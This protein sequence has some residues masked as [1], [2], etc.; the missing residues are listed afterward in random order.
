[1]TF[2]RLFFIFVSINL[3][4]QHVSKYWVVF[5]DKPICKSA[6]AILSKRCLDNRM[7]LGIDTLQYTD[8]PVNKNY[9]AGLEQTGAAI[10]QKSK[11]LNAVSVTA[12]QNQLAQIKTLKYVKEILPLSICISV[13][14]IEKSDS[15]K[16]K[17]KKKNVVV[18]SV[19]AIEPSEALLS[20]NYSYFDKAKLS[21][22]GVVVGVADAGYLNLDKQDYFKKAIEEGRV[23]GTRDFLAPRRTVG[24]FENLTGK[25]THGR[26]VTKCI[27]GKS[28]KE[29][30]GVAYNAS[31]Y[32]ARTENAKEER[33]IEED[34]WVAAIEWFDSL[35]VRLVNSSLGYGKGFDD[36]RESYTSAE[37]N[38]YTTVVA[39]AA[40]IAATQ[41][42]MF[43]VN[44]AGNSGNDKEWKGYI[45]SPGDAVPVL[46]IGATDM[47]AAKMGYSSIG[48]E[49]NGYIKPDVSAFSKNGT[50][51][52]SPLIAGVV[53][54]ILEKKG[55][56]CND[57]IKNV[58]FQAANLY[59]YKNNYLGYGVPN[60]DKIVQLL[61]GNTLSDS[62]YTVEATDSTYKINSIDELAKLNS[63]K[64][65]MVVFRTTTPGFVISSETI[66]ANKLVYEFKQLANESYCLIA[67]G[68]KK[69]VIKWPQKGFK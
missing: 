2:V 34:A 47:N 65:K 45:S 16:R 54:C 31:F 12:S 11:W 19:K 18:D 56:W 63:G 57:Q 64:P 68:N 22:K 10:V 42:E 51:F 6:S 17:K 20:I 44:S 38:G 49:Y 50:S 60:C 4:A 32:F 1:M 15:L 62:T 37:M 30:Y 33:R 48:P 43:L 67:S 24:I 5:T 14:S 3:S 21:G 39:K 69:F 29:Q 40:Q 13:A 55:D 7:Q 35:G 46:T 26:E 59:P 36:P 28:D 23:L 52:S 58:L 61:N 66:D 9:V 8:F 25:D 41:K 53:A 27:A